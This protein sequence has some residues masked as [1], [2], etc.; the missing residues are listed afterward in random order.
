MSWFRVFLLRL[1]HPMVKVPPVVDILPASTAPEAAAY[2]GG[3]RTAPTITVHYDRD[4]LESELRR[5]EG[6]RPT[7][8]QDSLGI[9]TYAV[10]HNGNKPL[11]TRAMSMILED[12]ILDAEKDLDRV[13]PTWKTELTERRKRVLLNMMFNM[14]LPTFEDGPEGFPKFWAAIRA[15]DYKEARA[16]MIDSKWHRQVGVRA[17]HLELIILEG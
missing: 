2:T 17:E 8:Y 1:Q 13:F 16:Q 7:I 12:D 14:G 6:V 9:W 4:L 15:K 11:S 10:G 5:D 3:A